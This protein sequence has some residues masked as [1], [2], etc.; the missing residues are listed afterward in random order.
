MHRKQVIWFQLQ[1]QFNIFTGSV[2]TFKYS[3]FIKLG[4]EGQKVAS[5]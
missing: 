3:H 2:C 1:T 5:H 4:V